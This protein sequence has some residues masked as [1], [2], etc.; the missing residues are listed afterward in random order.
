MNKGKTEKPLGVYLETSILRSLPDD[1]TAAAE[2]ARLHVVCQALR[3]PIY[4]PEL[5]LQE[6]LFYRE[7]L[8]REYLLN[9]EK[10]RNR[11]TKL[12]GVKSGKVW[13]K[14][15][16]YIVK[17]IRRMTLSQLKSMHIDII[18]TPRISLK[19]LI[20]M[21]VSKTRPFEEK[22][23]KGFRDS[24]ILFTMINYAK[25]KNNVAGLHI[26]ISNDQV[27]DHQDVHAIAKEN[28]VEYN[29]VRSIADAN[30]ILLKNI[31]DTVK[32]YY[33][34]LNNL[35]TQYLEKE[36]HIIMKYID[37]LDIIHHSSGGLMDW[38]L[39]SSLD[40]SIKRIKFI[41]FG[42]IS[43]ATM[44]EIPTDGKRV[45]NI[46]FSITLKF[47][48]VKELT[49]DLDFKTVFRKEENGWERVT[50]NIGARF[51]AESHGIETDIEHIASA[52]GSVEF[53]DLSHQFSNLIIE[54]IN[55]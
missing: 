4:I 40:Y 25:A 5:V 17:S 55:I 7:S 22:K 36:K 24:V 8:A 48:V 30:D 26:L 15:P 54:S 23:E 21:A 51:Y 38:P 52:R 11:I 28:N 3:I 46:S 16:E 2:L 14:K 10:C 44:G 45:V 41:T 39:K 43:A 50:E 19:R 6:W 20:R 47:S 12:S 1:I 42:G 9:N 34:S 35:L 33:E 49:P 13:P 32:K 53:D 29:R 31:K 18:K 37:E 27:F